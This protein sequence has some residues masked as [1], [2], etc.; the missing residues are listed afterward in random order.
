MSWAQL[1][2]WVRVAPEENTVTL[3]KIEAPMKF[4]SGPWNAATST[5]FWRETW[6]W[7]L[8]I[9]SR[10]G[11]REKRRWFPGEGMEGCGRGGGEGSRFSHLH[12]LQGA[13]NGDPAGILLHSED[14]Q[15]V[16]IHWLVEYIPGGREPSAGSEAP[17][18][19]H[20]AAEMARVI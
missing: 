1:R 5:S 12:P 20:A 3:T 18:Q 16:P 10:G 15:G 19:P 6:P 7:P 14:G 17:T 8:E 13:L 2:G 4:S 9:C 11:R